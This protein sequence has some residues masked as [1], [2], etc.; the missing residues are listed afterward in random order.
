MTR[1]APR[2]PVHDRQR[3]GASG[4]GLLIGAVGLL[5][6]VALAVAALK[7]HGQPTEPLAVKPLSKPRL[8]EGVRLLDTGLP[9]VASLWPAACETDRQCPLLLLVEGQESWISVGPVANLKDVV[10]GSDRLER[11]GAI[12]GPFHATLRGKADWGNEKF[13]PI[14]RHD[15]IAVEAKKSSHLAE[16]VIAYD[17]LEHLDLNSWQASHE[18]G[19]LV[20]TAPV[21]RASPLRSRHRFQLRDGRAV[22]RVRV[23]GLGPKTAFGLQL[24]SHLS[25]TV[26]TDR[27]QLQ[28]NLSG[29]VLELPTQASHGGPIDLAPLPTE[30]LHE[31]DRWFEW[32]VTLEA[33]AGHILAH[34][35]VHDSPSAETP[36]F[37][38][39]IDARTSASRFVFHPIVLAF[40]ST[41]DIKDMIV[42]LIQFE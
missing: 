13:A 6:L 34:L 33:R 8:D 7:P 15:L 35:C 32:R 17:A 9:Q 5:T 4:F 26:Q 20:L 12:K 40:E 39:A 1:E 27:E 31:P 41:F 3:N 25:V 37:E 30:L 16:V 19:I 22:M 11:N 42:A 28:A 36:L 38:V 14:V 2:T 10:Y 24:T 29:A 18:D 23:R 21:G